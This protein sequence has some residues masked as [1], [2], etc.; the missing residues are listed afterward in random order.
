MTS[1]SRS[2]VRYGRPAWRSRRRRSARAAFPERQAAVLR[3]HRPSGSLY[4]GAVGQHS[5]SVPSGLTACDEVVGQRH[6]RSPVC[7]VGEVVTNTKWC[8]L[9]CA[10]S[11]RD[12][13]RLAKNKKK[14]NLKGLQCCI[15]TL[16]HCSVENE[17]GIVQS[18]TYVLYRNA[19]DASGSAHPLPW[20]GRR[21]HA[22]PSPTSRSRLA[23]AGTWKGTPSHAA[24]P[25]AGRTDWWRRSPGR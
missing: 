15:S 18:P 25:S 14:W 8:V 5:T 11:G 23:S 4:Q 22:R 19:T 6:R 24:H 21:G 10:S 7:L 12:D 1:G 2:A 16:S 13:S 9:L 17:T 3:A 20:C